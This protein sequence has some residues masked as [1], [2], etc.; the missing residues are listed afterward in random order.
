MIVWKKEEIKEWA[1][2]VAIGVNHGY[3]TEFTYEDAELDAAYL[4]KCTELMAVAIRH[5]AVEMML[6]GPIHLTVRKTCQ[7]QQMKG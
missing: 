2:K 7:N 4:A 3:E 6:S 5:D 1:L